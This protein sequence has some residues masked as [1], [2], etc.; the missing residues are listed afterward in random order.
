MIKETYLIGRE[1]SR[2]EV[3][4]STHLPCDETPSSSSSFSLLPPDT[5]TDDEPSD[6]SSAG[7][8]T[9]LLNPIRLS[10]PPLDSSVKNRAAAA[11]TALSCAAVPIPSLEPTR[12]SIF[13]CRF[14][15]SSSLRLFDL[16]SSCFSTNRTQLSSIR[17]MRRLRAPISA[18]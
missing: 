14:L 4:E 16:D 6:N 15:N 13:S 17:D 11:G 12:T 18:G 9:H 2:E 8:L 7:D 3:N 5:P 10:P 1:S